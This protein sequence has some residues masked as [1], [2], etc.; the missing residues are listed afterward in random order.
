M[1]A[2]RNGA[3]AIEFYKEAFG[4]E[5]LWRVDSGGSVV[6][7]LKVDDAVFFLAD[8]SPSNGTRGPD[9]VGA[10]TVRIELFVEDPG[11]YSLEPSPR[12]LLC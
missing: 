10:T 4:A 9:S 1:L 6:A 3:G 7:G 5:E 12:A 11:Q 2:V 8:E